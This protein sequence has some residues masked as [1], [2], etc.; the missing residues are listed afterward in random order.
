MAKWV[1][2]SGSVPSHLMR[3]SPWSSS[4]VFVPT[5]RMFP[6]LVGDHVASRRARGTSCRARTHGSRRL[7]CVATRLEV[8]RRVGRGLAR[9]VEARLAARVRRE[10]DVVREERL[11]GADALLRWRLAAHRLVRIARARPRLRPVV[12]R[13]R[14]G[15][16][17]QWSRRQAPAP[18]AGSSS[19]PQATNADS[20]I[21]R[22]IAGS[23][24]RQA[25]TT[26]STLDAR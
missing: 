11:D 15:G 22:T 3:W 6:R 13:G 25:L 19:P 23:R 21:P 20:T 9:D 12:A 7:R 8:V 14:G 18:A 4:T 1:G 10:L 16:A 2:A 26:R 24:Q 5:D 17:R